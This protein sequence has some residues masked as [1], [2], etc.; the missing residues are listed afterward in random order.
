MALPLTNLVIKDFDVNELTLD[1]LTLF[2]PGGFT[3]AGFKAFLVAHTTWT[4]SE[5]GAIKLGELKTIA[6][7][8][9]RAISEAS[10]PKANAPA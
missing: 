9:G 4:K 3:A 2:E 7:Q 6:E 8:L 5:I 1:E 10:V